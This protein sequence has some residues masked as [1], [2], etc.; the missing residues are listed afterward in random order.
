MKKISSS[1][2]QMISLDELSNGSSAFHKLH[3]LAKIIFTLVYIVCTVSAANT[4]IFFLCVMFIYPAIALPL[5]DIPIVFALKRILPALPFVIFAVI[6]NI[7]FD[8]TVIFYFYG[9]AVTSGVITS[10]AILLK[11]LLAVISVVIL[12]S[13]TRADEL[14]AQLNTLRVPKLLISVTVL[15]FRYLNTLVNCAADMKNAYLLRAYGKKGVDIRDSGKFL[16][17]L[18]IR[19]ADKAQR[20]YG[21]MTLRGFDGVVYFKLRK[22][23]IQE[24]AGVIFLSALL[25]LLRVFL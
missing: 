3:P 25:I 20:I 13:T 2:S 15:C 7:I 16:G 24:I 19:T 8:R 23:K 17:S 12:V 21:A 6:T 10:A 18:I 1:I 4:D 5:A 11:T 14:I 22:I 9:I